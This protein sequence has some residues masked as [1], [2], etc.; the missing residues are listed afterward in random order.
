MA[1]AGAE[2]IKIEPP[3][4][5]HTRRRQRDGGGAHIPHAMLNSGKHFVVLDLKQEEGKAALTRLIE[6]SDVLVENFR[7]GVMARDRKGA[8]SGKSV[9]VRVVPGGRVNN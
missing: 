9:S 2:V 6:Q 3:G 7:P 4:G 1:M 8:V 5:E